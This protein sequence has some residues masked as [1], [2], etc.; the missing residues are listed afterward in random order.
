MTEDD[1]R[2]LVRAEGKQKDFA[3]RAGVSDAHLSLFLSGKR[4]PGPRVLNAL[5]LEM[6]KTIVRSFISCAN[7]KQGA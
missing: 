2:A 7:E 3:R 1:V 4:H 6:Q 5:G